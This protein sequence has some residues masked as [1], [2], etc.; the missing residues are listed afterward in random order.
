MGGVSWAL[1]GNLARKKKAPPRTLQFESDKGPRGGSCQRGT[2]VDKTIAGTLIK[3]VGPYS[4][5]SLI[6]NSPPYDPTVDNRNMPRVL[7]GS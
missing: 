7:G 3:R 4:S 6:R 5:N 2:P 1:Q